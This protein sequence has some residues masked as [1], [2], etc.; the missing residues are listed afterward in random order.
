[1]TKLEAIALLVV[2]NAPRLGHTRLHAAASRRPEQRVIDVGSKYQSRKIATLCR[3]G[4]ARR[5]L[6]NA[7]NTLLSQR[8]R[9]GDEGAHRQKQLHRRLHGCSSLSVD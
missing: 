5:R 3:I 6:F 7:E 1:M 9:N 8:R 2:G 4:F